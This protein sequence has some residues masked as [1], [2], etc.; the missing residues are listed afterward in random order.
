M[1]EQVGNEYYGMPLEAVLPLL[2]ENDAVYEMFCQEFGADR[3]EELY[4]VMEAWDLTSELGE[5]VRSILIPKIT[6]ESEV[7]WCGK[8]TVN[9]KRIS[10]QVRCYAG[11]YVICTEEPREFGY[12]LSLEDA[13]AFLKFHW[14]PV[15]GV[16]EC[17]DE[18]GPE[19][20]LEEQA[21]A[22]AY[23]DRVRRQ[24]RALG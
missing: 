24:R 17:D 9:R 2:V 10:F 15:A 11:I 16:R 8:M 22:H 4:D 6:S 5:A 1:F 13:R 23:I 19:E 14:S 20:R 12:F 3:M 7:H 21:T 18:W